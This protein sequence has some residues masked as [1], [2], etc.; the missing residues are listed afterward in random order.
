M[1]HSPPR[2]PVPQVVCRSMGHTGGVLMDIG[3]LPLS[4][5]PIVL[6]Q[7]ACQGSE[8]S[9]ASCTYLTTGIDCEHSED[10]GVLCFSPSPPPPPPSPSLTAPRKLTRR[11]SRKPAG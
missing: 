9:L 6:D 7:L 11:P 2:V 1:S 5:L 4:A 10:I 8:A 3:H